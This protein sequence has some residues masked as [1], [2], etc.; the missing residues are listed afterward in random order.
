[1]VEFYCRF[2][3]T[4][5]YCQNSC[6]AAGLVEQSVLVIQLGL[7]MV[8]VKAVRKVTISDLLNSDKHQLENDTAASL[9]QM[10]FW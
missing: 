6:T 5:F 10:L 3:T 1:M 9:R 8:N 4:N 2:V 7:Q